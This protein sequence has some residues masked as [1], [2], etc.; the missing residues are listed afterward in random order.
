MNYATGM[1][2]GHVPVALPEGRFLVDTGSSPGFRP[3]PRHVAACCFR[4]REFWSFGGFRA[5][6]L[7][8]SP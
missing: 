8:N 5:P 7:R 2:D 4:Y 6:K 3:A 1:F